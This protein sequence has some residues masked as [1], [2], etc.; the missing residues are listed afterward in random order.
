MVSLIDALAARAEKIVINGRNTIELHK[1]P[2][3]ANRQVINRV[4]PRDGGEGGVRV[5]L[6]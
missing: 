5:I 1:T 2:I 6:G 4:V 3:N